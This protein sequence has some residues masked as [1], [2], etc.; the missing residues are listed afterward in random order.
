ME[1]FSPGKLITFRGRDWVVLPSDD[2]DLLV[3]KPLGGTDHEVAG[4]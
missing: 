2:E 1:S 3:V 4:V